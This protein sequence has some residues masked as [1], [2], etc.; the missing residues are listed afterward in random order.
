MTTLHLTLN[1]KWFDMIFR[2]EKR[3]EYREIKMYW[4][5]R[6][7]GG[8]PSTYGIDRIHPDFKDF[9]QVE[10]RNGYSKNARVMTVECRG[11]SIGRTKPEWCDEGEV[12]RY[13][14]KLGKVLFFKNCD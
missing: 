3:E 2:G 1:K 6:L 11:I 5:T 4:A 14:I 12:E 7:T 9:D 13:V 10:F 8:F